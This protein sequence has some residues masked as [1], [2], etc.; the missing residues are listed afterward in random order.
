[1]VDVADAVRMKKLTDDQIVQACE[2]ASELAL[3]PYYGQLSQDRQNALKRYKGD[4]DGTEV[5]GRSQIVT[6]DLLDTVEWIMP[7]LARIFLAG[8]EVGKFSPVGEQ[9]EQAAEDETAVCN[10]TVMDRNDGYTQLCTAMRDALTSAGLP[11]FQE[12]PIC[13]CTKEGAFLKA[14]DETSAKSI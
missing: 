12:R 5:P 13:A 10:W 3:D 7:S 14:A 1:M 2:T 9:D 11:L 4:P 8:D 6:R